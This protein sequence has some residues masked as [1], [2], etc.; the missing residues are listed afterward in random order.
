MINVE[1]KIDTQYVRKDG[2]VSKIRKKKRENL[3]ATTL[4]E[5]EGGGGE[6]SNKRYSI[7][8]IPFE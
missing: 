1:P 4:V 7:M 3:N 8:N 6:V 5:G 2:N